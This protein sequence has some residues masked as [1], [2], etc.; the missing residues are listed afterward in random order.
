MEMW[1][2]ASYLTIIMGFVYL[3]TDLRAKW[4]HARR[5]SLL[6][7]VEL[8]SY[9]VVLGIMTI[10]QRKG[11]ISG[12]GYA[13]VIWAF[14]LALALTSVYLLGKRGRKTGA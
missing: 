6:F 9:L 4:G 11:R 7:T 3:V 12:E 13:A 2:L 5:V 10:L 8:G 1:E 14:F